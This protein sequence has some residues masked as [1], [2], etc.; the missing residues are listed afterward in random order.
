MVGKTDGYISGL[1]AL[2]TVRSGTWVPDDT[3]R[4]ELSVYRGGPLSR[5]NSYI[6]ITAN[7]GDYSVVWV[8]SS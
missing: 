2:D 4:C 7:K 8:A 1:L 3:G 6:L 5:D